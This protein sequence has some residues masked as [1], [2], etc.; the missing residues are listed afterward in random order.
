MATGD[1]MLRTVL[2]TPCK[3]LAR[4]Y[5]IQRYRVYVYKVIQLWNITLTKRRRKQSS[6]ATINSVLGSR[7]LVYSKN[8][9]PVRWKVPERVKLQ[10]ITYTPS[11][12]G[13]G[14]TRTGSRLKQTVSGHPPTLACPSQGI[15]QL[16]RMTCNNFAFS[17]FLV[18]LFSFNLFFFF[19]LCEWTYT[20]QTRRIMIQRQPQ[21]T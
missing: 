6:P 14:P 13:A 10:A 7:F 9:P 20:K 8:E 21:S 3:V 12:R 4:P 16:C 1:R 19:R 2:P 11:Q 17:L 15:P 5:T 18:F